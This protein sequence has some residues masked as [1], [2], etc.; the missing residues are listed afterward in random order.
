VSRDL[1]NRTAKAASGLGVLL[2][3]LYAATFVAA[4]PACADEIVVRDLATGTESSVT[5]WGVTSE[6]WSEVKYKERE[7]SADKSVPTITV[8]R[9]KRNDKSANAVNLRDAHAELNRGS[10]REAADAL[11]AINGGGMKMDLETGVRKYVS[12]SENDPKGR[13]KRPSWISEYSHFYYAEALYKLGRKTKD[14]GVLN[15]AL[16]AVDDLPVEGGGKSG[17]FLGRFANGNSRFYPQALAI[18]ADLLVLLA[19]YDDAVETFNKL[20]NAAIGVPLQPRW[21]YTGKIGT[22]RIAE[23]K[24]DLNGAVE[25][26]NSAGSTLKVLL[27]QEHR[28]WMLGELGKYYSYARMRTAAVMLEKAEKSKSTAEFRALRNWIQT[29]Q[30]EAIRKAGGG[31]QDALAALVAGARDP[32]VQAVGLNGMGLAYLSE[33]EPKYEDALLAFKAVTVKYF[34][35]PEQHARALYYLAKAAKGAEGVAKPEAKRMYADM[36]ADAVRMLRDQH[37]NSPWAQK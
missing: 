17:G 35:E 29:S 1:L 26:Y 20:Y 12:F 31:S 37:P 10:Y 11:Q 32:A 33:K 9:I 27:G 4:V 23:A 5:V 14:N 21:A 3:G 16:W 7:R 36:A 34:Q 13:N 22:G 24:G 28:K 25:A 30:P 2:L 8:V 19:R 15:E 18:K 6:S